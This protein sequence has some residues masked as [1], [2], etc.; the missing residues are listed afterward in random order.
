LVLLEGVNV[1]KT[2][3]KA[4]GASYYYTCTLIASAC[5]TDP[6]LAMQLHAEYILEFTYPFRYDFQD[7][8]VLT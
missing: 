6:N 8:I 2:P 3:L 1:R 7:K 5:F 4:A